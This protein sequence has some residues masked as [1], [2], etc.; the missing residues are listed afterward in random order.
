MYTLHTYVLIRMIKLTLLTEMV[1]TRQLEALMPALSKGIFGD[2]RP[3]SVREL[4]KAR[5]KLKDVLTVEVCSNYD[6]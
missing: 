1:S 4:R 6:S 2:A 3:P 5:K